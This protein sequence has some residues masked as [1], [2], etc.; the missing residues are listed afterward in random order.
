MGQQCLLKL[1]VDAGAEYVGIQSDRLQQYTIWT[2]QDKPV[3]IGNTVQQDSLMA[4]ALE[5]LC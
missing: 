4:S 5:G 3:S 2:L 1:P